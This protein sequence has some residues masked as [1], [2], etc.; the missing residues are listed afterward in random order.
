MD[1]EV[2]ALY[3]DFNLGDVIQVKG[4]TV[5]RELWDKYW[6]VGLIRYGEMGL[7]GPYEDAACTTPYHADV[8]RRLES[9]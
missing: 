4:P 5:P 3:E 9:R 7:D 6:R 8:A 1:G 2:K